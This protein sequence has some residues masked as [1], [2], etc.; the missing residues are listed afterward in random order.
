[1]HSTLSVKTVCF[2]VMSENFYSV[3]NA[4]SVMICVC[5]F[6]VPDLTSTLAHPSYVLANVLLKDWFYV[7]L[8]EHT[9]N[10]RVYLLNQAR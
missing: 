4:N 3:L 5:C 9:M 6:N 8:Q 10:E 7:H 2:P 1:M